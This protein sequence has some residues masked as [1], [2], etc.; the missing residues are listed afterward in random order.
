MIGSTTVDENGNWSID[1]PD[2]VN[3]TDTDVINATQTFDGVTSEQSNRKVDP[4][5]QINPPNINNVPR[6]ASS[7][8]GKGVP[9]ATVTVTLADGTV[10]GTAVVAEE[11]NW[12]VN[13]PDEIDLNVGDEIDATQTLDGVTSDVSHVNVIPAA[14][15]ITP[16]EAGAKVI[17]GA[18]DPGATV[19]VY[20]EDGTLIGTATVDDFGSWSIDVPAGIDLQDGDK[21]TAV[22]II[23]GYESDPTE[24]VVGGAN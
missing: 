16:P 10:I 8:T 17:Q 11:G 23:D 14:P 2:G 7:I 4:Q 18:G 6:D 13:L 20:A 15:T 9:G 1:V 21:I 12:S 5:Q 3:L 19:N 24:V 22:E